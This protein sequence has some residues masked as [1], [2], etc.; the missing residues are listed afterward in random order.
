MV[1]GVP[2]DGQ[3]T[4]HSRTSIPASHSNVP[5]GFWPGLIWLRG[6]WQV[7][8]AQSSEHSITMRDYISFSW[9]RRRQPVNDS[10]TRVIL[11]W[12]W[13][14]CLHMCPR[15][16]TALSLRM[17]KLQEW[18]SIDLQVGWQAQSLCGCTA[19]LPVVRVASVCLLRHSALHGWCLP[20]LHYQRDSLHHGRLVTK[21][22]VHLHVASTQNLIFI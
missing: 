17:S 16:L 22:F 21:S 13:S 5:N 6:N 12:T 4:V 15:A 2:C 1:S 8:I 3:H 14:L 7:E 11:S 20:D 18:W 9:R 10:G 19:L